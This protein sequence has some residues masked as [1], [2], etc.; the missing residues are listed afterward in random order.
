M[1]TEQNLYHVSDLVANLK[2][3]VETHFGAVLVEGELSNFRR[4]RSGH[5]YFTLKDEAAQLRCVMWKGLAQYVFFEPR[6]GMLVRV[7]GHASVYDARGELQLVTRSMQLAGEGALQKA[8]EALKQRLDAEGLFSPRHKRA[9]PPY[10]ETIGIITSGD[11]AALHDI[12]SILGRRFPQ[13]RV[14]VCPVHVQGLGASEEIAE[15]I[16]TFNALPAGDPLR[17]DVLITGRGGGSAE[18]LW[19]FNEEAVARAIFDADIPIVSAVGHETDYSI[20]DFVADVRAATPSMA[21]ELV[22]PDRRDVAVLVYGLYGYLHDT[23]SA[24]VDGHRQR[25]LA[26]TRSYRFHKPVERLRQHQQRLDEMTARLHRII[27]HRLDGERRRVD[28]LERRLDVL[29][30]RRPLLRGYVRV[31]RN[32][33]PVHEAAHLQKNDQIVLHFQDGT[34]LARIDT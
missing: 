12:V 3:V 6:D 21:A 20:S 34:R 29:D 14:L 1:E 11:G 17:P 25:I 19:A 31:E 4:Y 5:C 15:A 32:G 27:R 23:V 30:P 13:V 10:P 33:A 8:F 2:E 18:D 22:V 16:R 24:Q 28:A 7:Q 26:L 9:L